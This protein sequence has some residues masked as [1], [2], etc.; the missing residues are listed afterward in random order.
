MAQERKCAPGGSPRFLERLRWLL[1]PGIN[2]H[3]RLRYRQ[4]P[5]LLGAAS[6]GHERH[7]LDAGCG[8]GMLSYQAYLKGNRVTGISIKAKEVQSCRRQFNEVLAIA[9]DLMSFTLANLY[10]VDYPPATFDEIICTEVLEHI[11]RDDEV[12]AK[13]WRLLKPGGVLHMTAPNADHPDNTSS[14]LDRNETGGHVRAGY[15]LA[16]SKALIEPMG[17]HIEE[18]R[19][20]GGPV[21]QAFNRRIRQIQQRMGA[22]AGLPLFFLALPFLPLDRLRPAAVPYSIYVRARKPA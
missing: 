5:A 6:S 12:V 13:F 7:I 16:T 3:A 19:G 14:E 2:L 20:L 17:F 11:R 21:R 4:L 22:S 18:T 10:E 9:P 1:F 8:N 15:T